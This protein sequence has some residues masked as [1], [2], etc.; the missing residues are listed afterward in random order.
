MFRL[1]GAS[2]AHLHVQLHPCIVDFPASKDLANFCIVCGLGF[3]VPG[4]WSTIL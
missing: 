3:R 4:L 1:Q 2:C